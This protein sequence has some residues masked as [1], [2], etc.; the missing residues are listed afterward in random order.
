MAK[1]RK[2]SPKWDIVDCQYWALSKKHYHG[3][4]TPREGQVR[5]GTGTEE[6]LSNITAPVLILKADA[7]PEIRKSNE[8]AAK[9]IRH[10]KL[11]HIQSAPRST[12]AHGRRAQYISEDA[13]GITQR[14]TENRTRP[15]SPRPRGGSRMEIRLGFKKYRAHQLRSLLLDL[16][17]PI[18]CKR[19]SKKS[20]P[21]LQHDFATL[22]VRNGD[23][24]PSARRA[25]SAVLPSDARPVI[26]RLLYIRANRES[27]SPK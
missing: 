4:Y 7:P 23:S 21:V 8:E 25:R 18:S 24:F 5:G 20:G 11:V 16:P 17:G 10:G 22:F 2:D 13:I 3:T 14:P 1:C 19:R 12:Q 6:L 9:V 26:S 27:A 15:D